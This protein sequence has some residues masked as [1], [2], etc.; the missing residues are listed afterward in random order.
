MRDFDQL[1]SFITK[2]QKFV[3]LA[4]QCVTPMLPDL[5]C[6]AIFELVCGFDRLLHGGWFIELLRHAEDC[7][8]VLNSAVSFEE[9]LD[10]LGPAAEY[11]CLVGK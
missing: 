2:F 3:E 10:V 5:K 6:F 7:C 11:G 4:A 8:R 1:S 9:G